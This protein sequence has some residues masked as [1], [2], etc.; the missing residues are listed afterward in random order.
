MPLLYSQMSL[1]TSI[2]SFQCQRKTACPGMLFRTTS[3][4][5]V[6]FSLVFSLLRMSRMP[7]GDEKK[8][9]KSFWK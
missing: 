7:R 5:L 4:V 8:V 3:M 9:R 6:V 2:P 1:E